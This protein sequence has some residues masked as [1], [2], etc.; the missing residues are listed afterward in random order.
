MEI[1]QWLAAAVLGGLVGG[2][3]LVSRYRDAPAG[4]L[5]TPP[6]I[7][8]V[9]INLAASMAALA[10]VRT[11]GW[12]F[13]LEASDDSLAVGWTQVLVAGVGAMGL[14]RT[15][16]FTVRA[17][18]RDVGVGPSSFLQIF[19]RAA[20]RQVDRS[21]A[22][23]RADTVSIVMK[24]VDYEKAFAALPPYCLALMQNLPD[25]T[26][27]QLRRALEILDRADID[28]D[29]K[30]RLLGLEL[31]NVVGVDVLK[32]AVTSLGD[33]IRSMASPA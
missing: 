9:G 18:D 12:K 14:F 16:L 30:T 8:Y 2:A 4:A 19:L 22:Q 20:D 17:G 27:Q 21:R 24:D 26:Q 29:V 10:L 33:E 13:G 5:K 23:V 11:F 3:E 31:V 7:L 1:L 15:S 28:P 32:T 6:A 25:E